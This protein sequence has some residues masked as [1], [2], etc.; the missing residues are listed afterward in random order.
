MAH[1]G[2]PRP[3]SP[4]SRP[5]AAVLVCACAAAVVAGGWATSTATGATARELALAVQLTASAA[6]VLGGSRLVASRARTG[7][8]EAQVWSWASRALLV[9]GLGVLAQVALTLGPL[10]GVGPATGSRD[11]RDAVLSLAVLAA[12][13]LLYQGLVRWNRFTTVTSDPGDWLNGLSAVLVMT[14]IGDLVLPWAS[15]PL[16]E[17]SSWQLQSWLLRSSSVLMLVGSAA[18]VAVIGGLLR[19]RRVWSIAGVLLVVTVVD[20]A[21][22]VPRVAGPALD[23]WPAA[24]WA[25]AALVLVAAARSTT[26]PPRA[27]AAGSQA[28]TVGALVVLLA[29]VAVIVVATRMAPSATTGAVVLASA[30]VLGVS[31]R[32]VALVRSLALVAQRRAEALTDDLTGLPNRQALVAALEQATSA[33]RRASLL[34][35]DLDDFQAVNDRFGQ[36]TG[37]ELLR[38]AGATIAATVRGR[39]VVA[40]LGGDEFAVLLPDAGV[41]LAGEVAAALATATRYPVTV[42]GRQLQVRGSLGIAATDQDADALA[43]TSA[44]QAERLLVQASTAMQIAKADGGRQVRVY[45]DQVAEV[46]REEVRRLE[47][48]RVLLGSPDAVRGVRAGELVMHY[49]PQVD[50]RTDRV[51]GV[52]ALVRWENPRLGLLGPGDFLDLVERNGLMDRLTATVLD[53]AARQSVRWRESGLPLRVSVN[54]SATCL[55]H[56]GLLPLLDDVLATTTLRAQDLVLEV[57]ETSLMADPTSA[58]EQMREIAARGIGISIDDYGTG[59]SSLGYLNDL[60]ATELK[61]DRSFIS[62]LGTDPRTAAIV[63][64]TVTLGHHLGLRLVAEGVEDEETLAAV[65]ELG[66]DEVQGYVHSRPLPA[67]LFTAWVRE[68]EA[69]RQPVARRAPAL[70]S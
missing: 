26:A 19:D 44:S 42:A 21:T 10:L 67:D 51:L 35:I 13:P 61:I 66:C 29:G 48:L 64:A 31:T 14:A 8:T 59:Y 45:D 56:P 16:L 41:E 70:P 58:L 1:R 47:E 15:S 22:V 17:W 27:R 20:N 36:R 33:G 39:G 55:G 23:G 38:A 65:R 53:H 7:G 37:D 43:T 5:V 68:R 69:A 49:Q 2:S 40:R 3:H 57:T 28:T 18:T 4:S 32:V 63:A 25:L 62:R 46:L 12:T 60:P 54:L 50:L 6:L 34:I 9:V 52:E 24:S 11:A 30:A